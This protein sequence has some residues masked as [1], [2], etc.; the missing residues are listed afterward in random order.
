MQIFELHFNPKKDERFFDSFVYEPESAYEK[1]LGNL[2]IVGELKNS[3][4]SNSNFLNNLAQNIKKNYYTLSVK[5]AEKALPHASK[6]ANEFLSEQI[7]NENVDWLGNLSLAILCLDKFNITFTKTGDIKILLLRGGHIIDAGANLDLEEIDPYPL[8]IFFNVVSGKLIENDKILIVTNEV[9][10][11]LKESNALSKLAKEENLDSKNIKQILP[12]SLFGEGEGLKVSGICFINVLT[13]ES[14]K[15]IPILFQGK[16]VF[17]LPK[18]PKLKIFALPKIDL[19]RIHL[20]KIHLPKISLK[21]SLIPKIKN[22]FR[23]KISINKKGTIIEKF[24]QQSKIKKNYILIIFLIIIIFLAFYLFRENN[25]PEELSLEEI[26]TKIE[27]AERLLISQN[28][29]EANSLFKQV[30]QELLDMPE[31]VKTIELKESIKNKLNQI[32][33]LEIIENPE[34]TIELKPEETDIEHL[35]ELYSLTGTNIFFSSSFI[36]NYDGESWQSKDINLPFPQFSFSSYYS[37][38]Y[39]LNKENCEIIKY[40][41]LGGLNWSSLKTWLKK[42]SCSNAQTIAIDGSVWILNNNQSLLRYYN[43]KLEETLSINIFPTLENVSI[44]KTR[45]DLSYVYLLEQTNKRLII[46]DKKGNLIKQFQSE[47]FNKLK[48]FD[49]S[50]DGKTIYILNDFNIYKINI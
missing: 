19:S 16:K 35:K 18:L 43:A 40:S 12:P 21:G 32:N 27:Q 14:N 48:D 24:K 1:K 31:T 33:K 20:P 5:S 47:Q 37:N 8:K 29:K 38:L 9:F 30:W 6:K 45:N 4:P 25:K 44:I 42:D 22:P 23:G 36:F 11:F 15:N 41:Y 46:I 49:I 10:N 50:K 7:K 3:L 34:I 17:K 26:Q 28:E 2:Y 13:K 39:F